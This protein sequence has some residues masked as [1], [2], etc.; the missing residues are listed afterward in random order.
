MTYEQI[1]LKYLEDL[2]LHD[3]IGGGWAREYAIRCKDTP[4]GFIGA[5]GDRTVRDMVKAGKLEAS[6]EGKFR[7][8]RY[9][10]PEPKLTFPD[11]YPKKE[12]KVEIRESQLALKI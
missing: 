5:R 10:N 1:I 2:R 6:F 11:P 9:R 7:I 4:W 8:V 12:T 3:P